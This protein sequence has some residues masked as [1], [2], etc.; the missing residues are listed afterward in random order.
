MANPL[1]TKRHPVMDAVGTDVEFQP[2]SGAIRT[3]VVP[4]PRLDLLAID[5]E[6]YLAFANAPHFNPA[7]GNGG[8]R[9]LYP[10]EYQAIRVIQLLRHVVSFRVSCTGYLPAMR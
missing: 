2:V 9:L 10:P 3:T 4:K 7:F 5:V 8:H 1:L 6:L